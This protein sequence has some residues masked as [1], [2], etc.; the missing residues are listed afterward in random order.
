MDYSE[1]TA[2]I[3]ECGVYRY[4][5]TRRWAPRGSCALFIMLNP[6]TA[7]ALEDD[8]TIRSCVRLASSAGH[9]A[10]EVVNLYAFRATDPD[11]LKKNRAVAFGPDNRRHIEEA[12]GRCSTLIAAWGGHKMAE[13]GAHVALELAAERSYSLHC[14]ETIGSG[15]PKHP[16]YIK[17]VTPPKVFKE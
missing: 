13:L 10:L 8:P 16:L 2:V 15:A 9:N 17:S 14:F 5:L 6:S 11:N 7:D 12:M 4:L 3:S 1:R